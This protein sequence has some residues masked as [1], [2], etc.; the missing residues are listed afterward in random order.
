VKL[1]TAEEM[2]ETDRT[3]IHRGVPSLLLMENAACRVVEFLEREF[4]PLSAQRILI[5]CGKGNNGGDGIAIA[6]QLRLRHAGVKLWVLLTSDRAELSADAEANLRMLDM[7]GSG[8]VFHEIQPEMYAATIVLDA[9]LGTGISGAA[10]APSSE[11]IG[12]L[13]RDWPFAKKVAIDIPSGMSSD[14]AASEGEVV[15]ADYTVTFT[16]PKIG[17]VQWPNCESVGEL[18]VGRIGCPDSWLDDV[19][20]QLSDPADFRVLF[21]PRKLESN[22]GSYGHVLVVGGAAGKTGA[23]EMTGLAALRVGAGLVTVSSSGQM[24]APELMTETPPSIDKKTVVAMGPGLGSDSAVQQ[25]VREWFAEC[26][27]PMVVD[28]DGLNALA[29]GN[30]WLKPAGARVFT[31][32]PG[33]IARLVGSTVKDVQADRLNIVRRFAADRGVILVLKGNR[34]VIATPDGRAWINPTG[35]PAMATA[36]TGDVLTGLIA[37]LIAQ[38]PDRI[39]LCVVAAVWL[40]GRCGELCGRLLIATDLLTKLREAIGE[41]SE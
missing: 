22:K 8:G 39:E 33:E 4:A 3:L 34:T 37:G 30:E 1:L 29:S 10:K 36:G 14:L 25:Q 6:R 24:R 15:R 18:I 41:F 27:L 21:A 38:H 20:L 12:R 28:A 23:A 17:M 31:P 11:W 16:A 19:R 7:C 40:H 5:V 13:N 2:R 9:L 35:T 32:H 26:P